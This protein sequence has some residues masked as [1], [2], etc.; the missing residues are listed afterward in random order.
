MQPLIKKNGDSFYEWNILKWDETQSTINQLLKPGFHY[1]SNLNLNDQSNKGT[2]ELFRNCYYITL[3][4]I[5]IINK[6]QK[7]QRS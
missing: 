5:A 7:I 1:F 2:L 6:L 4:K 3:W